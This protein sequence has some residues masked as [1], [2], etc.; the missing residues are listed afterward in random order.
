MVD[1]PNP[2][3]DANEA[4]LAGRNIQ[5]FLDGEILMQKCRCRRLLSC[6]RTLLFCATRSPLDIAKPTCFKFP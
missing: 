4:L 2:P 6:S 5:E 3:K 1:D